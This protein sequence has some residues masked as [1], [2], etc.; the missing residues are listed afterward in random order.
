MLLARWCPQSSEV[1]EGSHLY[2]PKVALEQVVLPPQLKDT[3]TTA[4][5]HF[6]KFRAYRT[7]LRA[8]VLD[9]DRINSGL[10]EIY[11]ALR[12]RYTD[13]PIPIP[14]P[15]MRSRYRQSTSFDEAIS[16]GVGLVLMLCGPSGTGKTMTCDSLFNL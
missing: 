1:V 16:Y 4:V 8:I 14:I 6:D 11:C 3:L 10:A 9:R 5:K 13:I 15:V 2:E 12:Y 7:V